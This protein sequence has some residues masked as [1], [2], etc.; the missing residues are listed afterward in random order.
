MQS[1]ANETGELR[2]SLRDLVAISMLPVVW[3]G[4]RPQEIVDSAAAVILRTLR[5]DLVYLQLRAPTASVV[6]EVAS[7]AATLGGPLRAPE[8]G[9]WLA[10]LLEGD[11]ADA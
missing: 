4:K 5:L 11:P 3:A 6:L 1:D 9:R 2:R 10:P 7:T 8:L